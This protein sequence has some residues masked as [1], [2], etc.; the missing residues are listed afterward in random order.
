MPELPASGSER[1]DR[2]VPLYPRISKA[3]VTHQLQ[4]KKHWLDCVCFFVHLESWL[5]PPFIAFSIH[6][7]YQ[8]KH[9]TGTTL[10]TLTEKFTTYHSS[11]TGFPLLPACNFDCA[12]GASP[13][14][15][16]LLR[17]L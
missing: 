1:H 9:N 16:S 4:L 2:E 10:D 11:L 13:S 12:V 7:I 5:N 14:Q 3:M 8:R 15:Q 17:S 6:S